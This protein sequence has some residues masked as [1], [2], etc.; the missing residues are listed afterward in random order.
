[1]QRLHPDT[2]SALATDVRRP[3]YDRGALV[4]GI[5]HLGLGA[6]HRA[7]QAVYTEDA[8]ECDGGD[9]GIVGVSLR[10][11]A[12]A[13]QLNPQS[14]LYSVLSEDGESSEVRLIGAV[15]QVLVAGDEL[16]QVVAQLASPGIRI[17]TLT[18]TEKAYPVA[19]DGCSL[20]I[21]DPA[22]AADLAGPGA[23]TTA[24]GV[25]ALGLKQRFEAGGAPLTVISCDNLSGN[26][27]LLGA[28]LRDY[29]ARTFPGVSAWLDSA[30]TF[31]C[32][33]VDRIVPAMTPQQKARQADALGLEDEGAVSTEPFSQWIVEDNFAAG[34]PAWDKVGV[35][36][37]QD[38]APYESIK[39]GL[40]NASHSAIA[41][42]GLL[43]GKE[44]V[45]EVMADA[46]LCGFVQRLMA[47]D[48]EPALEVPDG[49]DL[50]QYRQALLARFS[51]PRLAHRC[52]QIA[53]DGSEKIRQ[54]WLPALRTS[55]APQLSRALAAWCVYVLD[56]E[57]ILSDP[58]ADELSSLRSDAG[59]LAGRLQSVLACAGITQETIPGFAAL[60][61]ETERNIDILRARGVEGL[62]A[63]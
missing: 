22:L 6:F 41:Y 23:P 28:L 14:G 54:R 17:V 15:Q 4:T 58:R 11:A 53:M 1:M 32:S 51:N 18:I 63:A 44:T 60:L 33:M 24:I 37:V 34:R 13:Q 48:L 47:D 5:V 19:Q 25:L 29:L 55:Q 38:I 2:L 20:D 61:A 36:F 31:P 46:E 7:H 35:Q 56:T 12:V 43:A 49:F 57:H 50:V 21:D 9:W 30:V 40:L 45:D 3:V 16:E 26:S 59:P 27:A 52:A 10:S 8:I 62:V 39:L 42:C